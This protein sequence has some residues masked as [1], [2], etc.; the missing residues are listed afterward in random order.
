VVTACGGG[1]EIIS[2][3]TEVSLEPT[4]PGDTTT[5]PTTTAP[6]GIDVMGEYSIVDAIF[7]SAV[8]VTL[9]D[10][11]RYITANGLPDHAAGEFPNANNPNSISAQS[12][13]YRLPLAPTVG[14][15]TAY[16]VP[17]S[18][19]IAVNGVPFDPYAAEWYQRDRT[20]G[21]QIE[22]TSGSIDLGLDEN[23]AHVQPTGAYHYHGIPTG[24]VPALNADAHSPLVGWAGDGLPI[25]VRYGYRDPMDA[26]SPIIDL[27]P[28]HQLRSGTRESGPGG[29][30]DGTYVEDYEHISGGGDLDES[31]GRFGITPEYPEGTYHY[32]LTEAFPV[33][34][35][36]LQAPIDPSFARSGR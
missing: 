6:A 4:V 14:E 24:L 26:T 10:T 31:N 11:Y 15:A 36:I 25:Y 5:L 12:Y 23:N 28:S 13:S 33:I 22:A 35:R 21:W 30:Y 7:G 32:V 3:T 16:N 1:T 19:G 17:Q 18:F 27:Q 34:P 29:A 2:A 20:S 8:A 9:D